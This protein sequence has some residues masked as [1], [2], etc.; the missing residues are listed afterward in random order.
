MKKILFIILL[1][2]MGVCSAN[3]QIVWGARVGLSNAMFNGDFYLN[4]PS[5]EGG[6]TVYYSLSNNTYLNS[7]LMFSLKNFDETSAFFLEL[8]IY[9]GYA[10]NIGVLDLYIQA[11]PYFGYKIQESEDMLD[12]FN[13]G[14]GGAAGIN[15]GRFKIEFGY[16]WGLTSIYH[17][18]NN[19]DV[20]Y[21]WAISSMFLGVS[22]IF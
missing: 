13:M 2:T 12:S 10:F 20:Q 11:G 5:I 19:Y 21:S 14:L 16:Q 15:L 9:A 18:T 4:S 17:N 6:P 22:Y 3:A 8:P 7:G 1:G